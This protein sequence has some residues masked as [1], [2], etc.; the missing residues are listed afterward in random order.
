M[1]SALAGITPG[2]PASGDFE[3]EPK[4]EN[5]FEASERRSAEPE[6]SFGAPVPWSWQDRA[7][8][9]AIVS[10][11]RAVQVAAV[12]AEALPDLRP[13]VRHPVS[14][15]GPAW[16]SAPI[17]VSVTP[18]VV[19]TP[20]SSEPLL[21]AVQIRAEG[22]PEA[23][24]FPSTPT[25]QPDVPPRPDPSPTEPNAGLGGAP[26]PKLGPIDIAVPGA[27]PTELTVER[28]RTSVPPKEVE[29][30]ELD[31]AAPGPQ[32]RLAIEHGEQP[33]R[34][35]YET[36]EKA[37]RKA[38]KKTESDV[39]PFSVPPE[40]AWVAPAPRETTPAAPPQAVAD[41][42]AQKNS[43]NSTSPP[44][45]VPAAPAPET[46]SVELLQDAQPQ[47]PPTELRET[48]AAV[49]RSLDFSN[50]DP[51]IA[52]TQLLADDPEP[53]S[54]RVNLSMRSPNPERDRTPQEPPQRAAPSFPAEEKPEPAPAD[55]PRE[56]L[57]NFEDRSSA[58]VVIPAES[59]IAPAHRDSAWKESGPPATPGAEAPPSDDLQHAGKTE[60]AKGKTEFA[61]RWPQA[62]G[63]WVELA[64]RNGTVDVTVRAASPEIRNHLEVHLPEL[65][66]DLE[67]A[68]FEV[69][70]ASPSYEPSSREPELRG[71][72][73]RDPDPRRDAP[74]TNPDSGGRERRDRRSRRPGVVPSGHRRPPVSGFE[75]IFIA[76]RKD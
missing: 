40:R 63:V 59:G 5:P 4:Q 62:G 24:Q 74:G 14:S 67:R 18:P 35:K 2:P 10:F 26:H 15:K 13:V 43:G 19:T 9:A 28:P 71:S 29:E 11:A 12:V 68:G 52:Y 57:Y 20:R 17:S 73:A 25:V 8:A 39:V 7:H 38:E 37:E 60:F 27:I 55:R 48:V 47:P 31:T 72:E 58:P 56:T 49:G 44:S 21:P 66:V 22:T 36:G 51:E 30:L 41:D 53:E 1:F 23:A 33:S 16:L 45:A 54:F 32:R 46:R 69:T 50:S 65:V 61:M 42:G 3:N 34:R 64:D 70:P 75:P 76:G 6:M